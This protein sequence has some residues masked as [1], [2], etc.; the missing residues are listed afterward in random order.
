MKI[1]DKYV[2]LIDKDFKQSYTNWINGKD[3][4]A[5]SS[6]Q[7]LLIHVINTISEGPVLEF[8]TGYN[9]TM[10]LH[11]I[12]GFQDRTLLSIETDSDWYKKMK[13]V[14][15]EWHDMQLVNP[16]KLLNHPLFDTHFS[17]AFI[18]GAPAELR[19]PFLEKI[20]ADYLIVH[21]TECVV[22]GVTNVYAFDFSMFKHVYHLKTVPPMTTLL[23]NLDTIDENLLTIFK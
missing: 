19:Q 13:K 12:T 3:T 17:V 18:D 8:G 4:L 5:F 2:N 9:S 20:N 6:H 14:E 7:P 11:T 21:D 10:I 23:S 16:R 15:S 1:N 22:Q